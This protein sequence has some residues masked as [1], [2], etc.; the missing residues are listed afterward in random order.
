MVTRNHARRVHKMVFVHHDGRAQPVETL[1]ELQKTIE[2][3]FGRP[4]STIHL[5]RMAP[6]MGR[7]ERVVY[8]LLGLST[9]T[10]AASLL[11]EVSEGAT[12]IVHLDGDWREAV[13]VTAEGRDLWPKDVAARSLAEFYETAKRPSWLSWQ[14][15]ETR[16]RR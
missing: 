16:K 14:R 12:R 7:V 2:E 11:V 10:L 8:R 15:T 5:A 6:P 13:A 4:P 9:E 3:A 1:T